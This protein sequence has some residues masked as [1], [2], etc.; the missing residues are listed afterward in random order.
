MSVKYIIA[1]LSALFLFASAQAQPSLDEELKNYADMCSRCMGLRTRIQAGD[2]V[3]RDEAEATIDLFLAMNRRLKSRESEMTALQRQRFKDVGEWFTTG[4]RPFRPSALPSVVCKAMPV[5]PVYSSDVRLAVPDSRLP[6]P[7]VPGQDAPTDPSYRYIVLAEMA[8]PDLAYGIRAGIMGSRL[9]GYASFRSNFVGAEAAY[10]CTSDGR[11]SNGSTMW[12]GGEERKENLA[13][14][15][16]LLFNTASW[17]SIYAGAGYGSRQLFWQD[18]DGQ[19]ARVSDWS[20]KG[21]AVESGAIFRW[22]G[23]AFSAG[24]STVGFRTLSGTFGIGYCF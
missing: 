12:A 8:V 2:N 17:L 24:V 10:E 22:N 20:A 5:L 4:I 19:W 23:L 13:V 14:T 6:E 21:L 16:G 9:G 15:A 18:I 1:V 3:S 7:V 11:L